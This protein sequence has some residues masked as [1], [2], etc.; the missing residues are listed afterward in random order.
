VYSANVVHPSEC[1]IAPT[2]LDNDAIR[3]YSSAPVLQPDPDPY[4]AHR[5]SEFLLYIDK[6]Y[7]FMSLY[8]M[9]TIS[10]ENWISKGEMVLIQWT[11][12][13]GSVGCVVT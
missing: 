2:L 3:K 12:K 1:Y 11:P 6:D 8:K 4:I 7:P 13:Y 10:M 9:L 5:I